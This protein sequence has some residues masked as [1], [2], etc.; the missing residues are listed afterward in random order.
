[1]NR[2]EMINEL[3][4]ALSK[5]Q[6]QMSGAKKDSE[7]PH[8]RSKYAD[9]ASVREACWKPLTDNGL[10]V[11]QSPRLTVVNS[12]F[13]A[14]V[15]TT[16]MHT[17]GQFITDTIGV[18]LT[19]ADAQGL[20]SAVT[21]ARRYALSA[22]AGIAPEDDDGNAAV[23]Q[24]ATKPAFGDALPKG[25]AE[26]L[27]D[28]DAVALEGPDALK[29]AWKESR[30]DFRKILAERDKDKIDVLKAKAAQNAPV[31]A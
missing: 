1:M 8:F 30:A 11:L 6:G 23:T 10:S 19:K 17:S 22:F 14:E 20:G 4:T 12:A 15:E 18:P 16:L 3:A 13:V 27:T 29:A 25:Y 5:A 2:S 9:L 21:Y 31:S 26:W 24:T 28:L 7:N